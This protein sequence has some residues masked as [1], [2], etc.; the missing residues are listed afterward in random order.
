[1][2]KKFKYISLILLLCLPLAAKSQLR[3]TPEN[4]GSFSEGKFVIT[5]DLR[6]NQNQQQTL[7]ELF[8][9]D[10]MLVNALFSR[11]FDYVNNQTDWLVIDLQQH[12]LSITK[13]LDSTDEPVKIFLTDLPPGQST[14]SA[15]VDQPPYGVNDLAHDK[16][17]TYQDGTACFFLSGYEDAREVILSGSFNNWSTMQLPMKKAGNGW[18]ICIELEPGKH[19]YKYIVDGRWITDPG[20]RLTEGFRRWERNSVVF[21]YNHTFRLEGYENARRVVVAGSFNFW[22]R[23]ELRM[24]RTNDVWKLPLFLREGTHAYKFIVDRRWIL[25]PEN[26]VT[27]PDGRGNQNSFV[28]IGD[29]LY[30]TLEGYPD[31][32]R[33]FVAGNFNAWNPA[34]LSM[35]KT[36]SGWKLPYVLAPGMYEYK[37][38]VD[39]S[40]ITDPNNPYSFGSGQYQNSVLAVQPNHQ[41]A[42]PGYEDAQE[43]IVTGSFNGWNTSGYRMTFRDDQWTLPIWLKPGRYSYKFIIDGEWIIDPENNQR[44]RNEFNGENSVLWIE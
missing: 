23:R 6:W 9:L 27:R 24:Q 26:P 8:D 11:D 4:A 25:D 41:F 18:K 16:A 13:E 37:F 38:I 20:N 31:A 5:V 44:E 35:E 3:I 36:D 40:W 15:W 34:E 19:L 21:A 30:F 42:L 33:V 28:S 2:T 22:R 29:T 32:S 39:G 12:R 1:M 43:V 14:F 10:T 7:M 17:F